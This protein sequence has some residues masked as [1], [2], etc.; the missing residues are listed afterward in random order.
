MTFSDWFFLGILA[1][2]ALSMLILGLKRNATS[3]PVAPPKSF[4][5][6]EMEHWRAVTKRPTDPRC[7]HCGQRF[8]PTEEPRDERHE[9]CQ[10]I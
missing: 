9:E 4:C 6:R 7:P 5:T 1:G 2:G 10:K 8:G 3:T